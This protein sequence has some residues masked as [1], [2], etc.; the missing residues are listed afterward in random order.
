MSAIRQGEEPIA[1]KLS[2]IEN[3]E[4][5]TITTAVPT[6]QILD[7]FVDGKESIMITGTKMLK[8]PYQFL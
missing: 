6:Q 8:M 1:L 7:F 3:P 5:D 2:H 4:G